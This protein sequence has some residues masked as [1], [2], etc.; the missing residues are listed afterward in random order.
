M[1]EL[2]RT[3]GCVGQAYSC[4]KAP[5]MHAACGEGVVLGVCKGGPS[6]PA[7]FQLICS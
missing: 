2:G 1:R 7:E 6:D 5:Q 3:A 4:C